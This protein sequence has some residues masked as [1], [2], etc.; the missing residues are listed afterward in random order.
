MLIYVNGEQIEMDVVLYNPWPEPEK[1][2]ED[3]EDEKG[4]SL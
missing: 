4:F 1:E 3:Q 2:I